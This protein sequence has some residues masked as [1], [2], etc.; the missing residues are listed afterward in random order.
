MK[1]SRFI[2]I[3]TLVLFLVHYS[4]F[5][6]N[7]NMQITKNTKYFHKQTLILNQ[8][9]VFLFYFLKSNIN[10]FKFYH[11]FTFF[12]IKKHKQILIC[13]LAFYFKIFF[14]KLI[15][16]TKQINRN[17]YPELRGSDPSR[18]RRQRTLVLSNQ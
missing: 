17:F 8:V 11:E 5:K 12:N 14:S 13:H 1:F 6:D 4:L 18:V 3:T 16:N 15:K 10:Q 2:F 7:K 9:I